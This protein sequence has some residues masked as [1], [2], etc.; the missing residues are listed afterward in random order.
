MV[1]AEFERA[2]DEGVDRLR[3]SPLSLLATGA[4]GGIDV[5]VGVFALFVVQ[6]LTGSLVLAGLAFSMGFV[7][8]TLAGSELFTENFLVPFVAVAAR[9]E[10]WGS[11]VRL[12]GG[13]L[14]AN[15]LGGWLLVAIIMSAFP[16]LDRVAVE[17]GQHFAELGI[18]WHSFSLAMLAGMIITLMTWMEQTGGPGIRIVAAVVAGFL[19]AVG[20]MNHSIVASLEM[21]AGL[22]VGAPY[23]YLDWLGVL[24]WAVLGNMVGGIGLV[25]VLR[26][27]QV[28]GSEIPDSPQSPGS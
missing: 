21:F 5:S 6:D 15:L 23:G 24:G 19:L 20:E 9:E 13:T 22:I 1:R 17:A 27:V 28:G 12:W 11:L 8:L 16:A 2:V 14:V 25:T 26:L 3:R 10:T 18:G 4:I 7:A